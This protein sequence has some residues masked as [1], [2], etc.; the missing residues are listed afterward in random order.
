ME[1]T[2]SKPKPLLKCSHCGKTFSTRKL[3]VLQAHER[4]HTGE[5]P[6]ECLEIGCNKRFSRK[7]SM[8]VHYLKHA[9]VHS[10]TVKSCHMTFGSAIDLFRHQRFHQIQCSTCG[11]SCET[12]PL[13]RMHKLKAHNESD[14]KCSV[15]ENV[16]PLVTRNPQPDK[17]VY[18]CWKYERA[19]QSFIEQT[20]LRNGNALVCSL[21]LID[22]FIQTL[23]K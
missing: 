14:F 11:I 6:F 5:L 10:C 15:G 22:V 12:V 23:Q 17:L 7:D 21:G 3:S 9:R 13:L 1:S 16:L 2:I 8:M 20:L 18:Y 19:Y 4:M